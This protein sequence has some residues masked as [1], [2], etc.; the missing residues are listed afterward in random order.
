MNDGGRV[1]SK[2]LQL[3]IDLAEAASDWI[4]EEAD[5]KRLTALRTAVAAYREMKKKRH[6]RTKQVSAEISEQSG[7]P[8]GSWEFEMLMSGIEDEDED[9]S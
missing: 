8:A 3:L 4:G 9:D 6:E 5:T 2:E 1:T 7:F